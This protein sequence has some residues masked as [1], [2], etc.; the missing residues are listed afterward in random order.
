MPW[1]QLYSV[2]FSSGHE[3]R[4]SAALSSVLQ[5]FSLISAVRGLE[6]GNPARSSEWLTFYG[7]VVTVQSARRVREAAGICYVCREPHR[8]T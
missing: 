8:L 6:L 5:L 3:G 1:E 4:A 2:F 7:G